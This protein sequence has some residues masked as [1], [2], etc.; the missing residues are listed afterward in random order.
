[1]LVKLHGSPSP[2]TGRVEVYYAG[3]WGAIYYSS[4]DIKDAKVVCRQL[5]YSTAVLAGEK[6]FCSVDL[7][8]WFRNFR[9]YGHETSLDQCARDFYR[10]TSSSDYCANVVC[11]NSVA[12]SG[13]YQ[14]FL[15]D[16]FKLKTF[17]LNMK[18][19]GTGQYVDDC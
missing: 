4:W 7:P 19:S 2:N 1:M 10:Y 17:R 8:L 3:M 13:K 11:S 6:V 15:A 12:N 14:F 16:R 18:Y 5:G 9:C